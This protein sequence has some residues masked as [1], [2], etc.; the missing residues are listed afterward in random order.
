MNCQ[1][2]I[3]IDLKLAERSTKAYIVESERPKGIGLV[4]QL[5][6]FE[7]SVLVMVVSSVSAVIGYNFILN[8]NA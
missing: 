5:P 2:S 3:D 1:K 6:G 4:N 8:A 7:F